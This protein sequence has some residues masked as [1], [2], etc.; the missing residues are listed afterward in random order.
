MDKK[1]LDLMIS[2]LEKANEVY[3]QASYLSEC[4]SNA[5]IRKANENKAEWLRWIIYLADRGLA[6][7]KTEAAEEVEEGVSACEDCKA[8]TEAQKLL[9][10]KDKIIKDLQNRNED[11]V[12]RLNSLQLSYDCE[13]E[14]RK[15]LA[16]RAKIDHF[17]EVL[18]VAH[19]R[20]WLDGTVLVTPVEYLDRSLLELIKE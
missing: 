15:A 6:A 2:A 8:I 11:L 3:S 19:D 13:L 10:A 4:G 12:A 18:R 14:Y 17:T 20:C 1:A 9:E 7:E 16:A 5:G